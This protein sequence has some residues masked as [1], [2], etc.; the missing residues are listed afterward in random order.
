MDVT[1]A[2]IFEII[3]PNF[4]RLLESWPDIVKGEQIK[5]GHLKL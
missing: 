4:K 5:Q 2:S 1:S 3:S